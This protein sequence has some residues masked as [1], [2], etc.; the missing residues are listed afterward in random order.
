ML[1]SKEF[2]WEMG[3][4]LPNHDG[5]CKNVH[6]HSY[7]MQVEIEGDLNADGMVIDFHDISAAVKPLVAELDHAFLCEEADEE[8]LRFLRAHNMKRVV[9]P[10]PSTVENICRLFAQELRP[11]FRAYNNVSFF[12]VRINETASS[13]AVL[14]VPSSDF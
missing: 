7:R 3:H 2:H 9:V 10:W 12:R 14:E 11:F 6:G 13:E 4:R 8:M 5:A 1:I